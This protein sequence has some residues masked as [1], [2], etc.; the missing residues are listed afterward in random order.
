MYYSK[1]FVLYSGAS[2]LSGFVAD[3]G[4]A[5]SSRSARY[6]SASS[7]AIHPEPIRLLAYAH[8]TTMVE[9]TCTSNSLPVFLILDVT[10]CEDARYTR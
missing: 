3:D 5:S 1:G 10:S 9:H 7:A 4:S 6:F 2:L 8:D